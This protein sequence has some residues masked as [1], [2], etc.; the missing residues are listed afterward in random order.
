MPTQASGQDSASDLPWAANAPVLSAAGDWHRQTID[1]ADWDALF[2][3]VAARLRH[4]VGEDL[5]KPPE[6]PVYSAALTASLIQ[7]VV[8]DCVGALDQ[9]HAALKQDRSQRPTP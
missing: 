1:A 6:V 2:E 8:L 4:A 3:A 7:A 9:L 5:H